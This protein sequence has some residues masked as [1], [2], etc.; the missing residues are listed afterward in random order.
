[1]DEHTATVDGV[2]VGIDLGDR[3]SEVCVVDAVGEVVEQSRLRTTPDAFR[4]RFE[5]VGACRIA[6]EAG[7]HSAW[8]NRV[9]CECGHET[10]VAN[11][12]KLRLIYENNAKCD[13]V[14]ALYLAR[15]ARLDPTL[16]SPTQPRGPRVQQDR[17][18]LRSREL[19]V[20][21]RTELINHLRSVVKSQ[22]ERWPSCSSRA[23]ATKATSHIPE[24]L[25]PVLKPLVD[26]VATLNAQI[27]EYDELLEQIAQK[28][29]PETEALRAIDGVGA[30]TS[31]AFVLT[32]DDPGRF[33]QSRTVGAYLGLVPRRDESGQSELQLRIT[34]AGDPMMRRLLVS[35]AHYVLGPFG[36]D[37][38]LRRWGLRLAAR[39]GK[40]AKKRSVVAVARKLAVLMH[41]LWVTGEVYRPLRER[42]CEGAQVL[43]S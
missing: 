5:G 35:A 2:T 24:E 3:Y 43:P 42:P 27:R 39:G 10:L 4:R 9:L 37:C 38:D 15:I 21:I 6:I 1:M 31:L 41:R 17:A 7:T 32:V 23:F 22:G 34:K 14:D 19:L 40:N 13:R 20:K 36:K 28:R 16:L 30:L 25:V 29:Y 26:Q 33:E 11:P 18:L 12:R 8:V